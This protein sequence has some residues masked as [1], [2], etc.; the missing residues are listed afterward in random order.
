MEG[1]VE[2]IC[3][4]FE[5]ALRDLWLHLLVDHQDG[6]AFV[7]EAAPARS[8]GHLDVLAAGQ[9][10]EVLSVEL[11]HGREDHGARG[12]VEA[13]GEGFSGEENFEEAEREEDLDDFLDDGEEAAVVNAD[14]ALEYGEHL[15]DLC[16]FS[17][18][19]AE[20]AHGVGVHGDDCVFLFVGGEVEL[21]HGHGVALDFALAE[22][23]HDDRVE[24]LLHDQLDDLVEVRAVRVLRAFPLVLDERL[25][26]RT[27]RAQCLLEA[28]LA[29]LPLLVHDQV[30]ALPAGREDV[31]LQR[32]RPEVRVDHVA[33]LALD[34]ADPLREVARV[35]DGGR[36]EDVADARRAEDHGFFPDDASLAVAHVVHLVEDDPGDFLRDL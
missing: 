15:L 18:F 3:L 26:A 34:P 13:H 24:L 20:R 11:A 33:G 22:G 14:A 19:G 28:L 4:A 6:D 27:H 31:V 32:H 30:D 2:R 8:A 1:R 29:E 16:E 5:H 12:H 35:G 17:V 23:E 25:H 7:V 21:E 10:A 9:P 36:E